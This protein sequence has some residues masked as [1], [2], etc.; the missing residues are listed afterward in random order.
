MEKIPSLSAW[1]RGWRGRSNGLQPHWDGTSS[2][3]SGPQ[4]QPQRASANGSKV[5]ARCLLS[6]TATGCRLFQCILIF[7][8]EEAGWGKPT[9]LQ[10]WVFPIFFAGHSRT[11][12]PY[13]RPPLGRVCPRLHGEMFSPAVPFPRPTT[14]IRGHKPRTGWVQSDHPAGLSLAPSPSRAV[15]RAVQEPMSCPRAHPGPFTSTDRFLARAPLLFTDKRQPPPPCSSWEKVLLFGAVIK[16]AVKKPRS[17]A[18]KERSYLNDGNVNRHRMVRG[19]SCLH[20]YRS[21]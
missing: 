9:A 10:D 2:P 4:S 16:A 13:P 1:A 14:T 21:P 18:T 11:A 17:F 19:Y 3:T 7:G 8:R 5:K 6:G 20:P 15:P 12:K